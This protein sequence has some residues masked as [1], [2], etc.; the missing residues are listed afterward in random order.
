MSF[1]VNNKLGLIN[2]FQFL[3]SLLDSLDKKKIGISG[4]KYLN[5]ES[6]NN[7]LE[8][9]TQK[10]FYPDEYTTDFEKFNEKLASKQRFY[11]SFNDRKV[12]DNENEHVLN[13]KKKFEMKTIITT[14]I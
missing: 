9:A 4:F 14:C 1:F 10:W 6:D 3:S 7:V 2:S 5:Q 8:L 11:S 12:S 13:V